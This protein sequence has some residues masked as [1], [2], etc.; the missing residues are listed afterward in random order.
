MSVTASVRIGLAVLAFGTLSACASDT[1][2]GADCTSRPNPVATA[3]TWEGLKA[4]M[5][6]YTE[7]GRI[8]SLRTQARGESARHALHGDRQVR[9]VVDLLDQN[10][11]RL[12]QVAVRR[13]GPGHWR[14]DALAECTD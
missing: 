7:R 5:L 13:T 9:R 3:S 14:A 4:A 8:G 11:R 6:D 1:G 2:G 10:G 12:E